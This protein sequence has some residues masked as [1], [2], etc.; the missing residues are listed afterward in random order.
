MSSWGGLMGDSGAVCSYQFIA[1]CLHE[2]F[3]R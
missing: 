3:A 1:C 2:W